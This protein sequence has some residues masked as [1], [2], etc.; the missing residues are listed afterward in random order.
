MSL[1]YYLILQD[2]E[3][4][5]QSQLIEK[6]EQQMLEQEDL[7]AQARKDNETLQQVLALEYPLYLTINMLNFL[8]EFCPGSS[9]IKKFY[10]ITMQ[11]RLYLI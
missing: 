8:N 6:M 3:I 1:Y 11:Q 5:K 7:I 2:E 9:V 10:N 4:D